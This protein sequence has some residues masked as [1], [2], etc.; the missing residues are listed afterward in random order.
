MKAQALPGRGPSVWLVGMLLSISAISIDIMLPALPQM[1]RHFGV[2]AA[3]VQ[4]VVTVFLLGFALPHLVVGAAAERFGR[5]PVLTLGLSIYLAGTA[6][7]LAAPGFASLLAGRFLQ[8]LGAA[9]GPVLARAV[10]RDRYSGRLLA[11]HLSL[12]MVFFAGG[13]VLAPSVG[14]LLLPLGGW[15]AIFVFLA[16]VG[17][18]LLLAVRR[19]LPETLAE[20]DPGALEPGRI[21]GAARAVLAHPQSGPVIAISATGYGALIAYLASAPAVYQEQLGLSAARFALVFA[22]SASATFGSQFLNVHL[23]KTRSSRQILFGALAA[24]WPVSLALVLQAA[25]GWTTPLGLAVTFGA[26][27]LCFTLM[28]ANAAA[29]AVDPHR[30]AAGVASALLGF[31]QLLVGTAIGAVIGR[32]AAGGLLA[33][34]LGH[35]AVASALLGLYALAPLRRQRETPWPSAGQGE[36]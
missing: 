8:G 34:G 32:F 33:L 25:L 28:M 27:L 17:A 15:R 3:A 24:W 19:L 9:S 12:A 16:L 23:L 5:R 29:L 20:A 7:T 18:L 13:P 14:A 21:L 11:R 30:G 36:P 35:L 26:F 22:L 6:L 10:L 2:G 31:T 4:G 1:A